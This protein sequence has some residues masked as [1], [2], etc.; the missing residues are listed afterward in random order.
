MT[1]YFFGSFSQSELKLLEEIYTAIVAYKHRIP[2]NKTPG[3]KAIMNV[4]MYQAP[5]LFNISGYRL[6]SGLLGSAVLPDYC[7]P[8]AKYNALLTECSSEVDEIT[9]KVSRAKL[10]EY[11][12]VLYVHNYL[13]GHVKYEIDQSVESHSIVGALL[14]S[15]GCCESISRAFKLILDKLQIPCICV[16]GMAR[17]C[18]RGLSGAHMWNMVLLK[19]EWCHIDVTFDLPYGKGR[20]PFHAF[21]G[22]N[23]KV[24]SEDHIMDSMN[25]YPRSTSNALSYFGYKR[26]YINS[27]QELA[28]IIESTARSEKK[29]L[30]IMISPSKKFDDVDEVIRECL[31]L[32]NRNS[33]VPISIKWMGN[34]EK[35]NFIINVSR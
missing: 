10:G 3:I 26:S 13:C 32:A 34:P 7:M 21:F 15:K 14:N 12:S 35:Q 33:S 19:G 1:V 17:D 18:V 8:N 9:Q 22:L 31:S 28:N 30:E 23:D 4:I 27:K 20:T 2:I 16:S 24:I 29:S 25:I 11:D 6:E 5:E